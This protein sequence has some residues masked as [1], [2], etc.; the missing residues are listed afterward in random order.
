MLLYIILEGPRTCRRFYDA[1][2]QYTGWEP[3]NLDQE[4]DL[5]FGIIVCTLYPIC[6][7]EIVSRN[8]RRI[9]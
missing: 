7:L 8:L 2:Q 5:G 3:T 4:W 6:I 1:L 9:W